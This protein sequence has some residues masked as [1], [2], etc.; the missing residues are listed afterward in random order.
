MKL[1][2]KPV[3]IIDA[4][5]IKEGVIISFSDGQSVLFHAEF[6]YERQDHDHNVGLTGARDDK[7]DRDGAAD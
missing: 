6:L 2:R 4:D 7:E 5:V 1:P 3:R